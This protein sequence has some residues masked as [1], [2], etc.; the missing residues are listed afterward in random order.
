MQHG[1]ICAK[2]KIAVLFKYRC[3][4]GRGDE[5]RWFV[6]MATIHNLRGNLN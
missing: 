2:S 5:A 3:N 1:H 6:A 4:D